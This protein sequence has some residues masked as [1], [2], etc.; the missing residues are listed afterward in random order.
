MVNGLHRIPFDYWPIV[1]RPRIEWPNNARLAFYIGLNVEHH[2]VDRPGM[3]VLPREGLL[4]PDP[5]NY[6]GRNYGLRVGI[7]RMKELFDKHE[8]RPSILLNSDVCSLYPEIIE[9]GNKSKWAWLAH[10]KNNS[11]RQT[12]MPLAKERTYLKQV[13]EEI[14]KC[15]GCKPKGWLGPSLTE[16]FNTPQILADL[17]LTYVCDWCS[18]DQPYPFNVRKGKMIYVPYGIEFNDAS[19]FLRYGMTGE[20]FYRSIVD[21]FDVLYEEGEKSGRVMSLCLHTFLTGQPFRH[22]YLAKAIDYIVNHDKVWLATSDEIA[23]WY[24]E[25]Y[26]DQ[27]ISLLRERKKP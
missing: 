20:D 17:G 27:A 10:G 21:Q 1:K 2:P 12:D 7:W 26:Y 4:V 22:K 11:I 19:M 9:E 23:D 15:T 25:H 8:L 13:V 14:E 5:P 16:T 24:Y 3:P 6:G 18:D